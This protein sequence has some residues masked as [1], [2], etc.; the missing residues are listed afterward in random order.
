MGTNTARG[1]RPLSP[2]AHRDSAVLASIDAAALAD[3][4]RNDLESI[5]RLLARVMRREPSLRAAIHAAHR[6]ITTG[7]ALEDGTEPTPLAEVVPLYPR[8]ANGTP[9]VAA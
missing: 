1:G 9:R 3:D 6:E 5:V 4:T 2:R 8:A 7:Q